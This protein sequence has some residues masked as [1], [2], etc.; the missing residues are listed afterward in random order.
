MVTITSA[1]NAL[2]SVYLEVLQNQLNTA[3]NPFLAKIKNTTRDVWGKEVVKVAP[4]GINGGIAAGTETGDL[5]T[6]ASNN[7]LQFKSTLKNLYGTI[8]ISDKAIRASASNAG[9]F[10]SL[11]NDEME[12]LIKAATFNF[13]RMV[14]GD[15]S[16]LL[17]TL[18]AVDAVNKNFTVAN[19]NNFIEG[20]KVD[21]VNASGSE[22]VRV[23]A[24]DRATKKVYIEESAFTGTYYSGETLVATSA[25]AS[26]SKDNEITGLGTIFDSAK[27]LYG[28][29]RTDLFSLVPT[30]DSTATTLSE[31]AMQQL[32]DDAEIRNG[33]KIDFIA[34]SVP[35]RRKYQAL[36]AENKQIVNTIDLA[37]GV[38]ALS[39]NGIPVVA[40]R[41]CPEKSMYFLDTN[42][43]SIHQLCDWK[44]LE[45]DNGKIL[46]QNAGKPT[47]NATL[48]KYAELICDLPGGQARFSNI[49]E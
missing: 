32:I 15:G 33:S 43:F 35:V 9:A 1:E 48:V 40:D 13:G 24:I 45:G 46:K 26:E 37:G 38:K 6:A 14:Y 21:L 25:Y 12:G 27:T 10:V 28:V 39:F 3:I 5:P 31:V 7:Y 17:S 47:Y 30:T 41:F 16:G 2:K 22:T 42:S 8:S 19:V 44:W 23:K 34:C 4:M 36:I 18:S 29:T 20:Q 49:T 11:L